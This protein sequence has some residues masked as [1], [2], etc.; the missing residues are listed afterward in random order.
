MMRRT[1]FALGAL[2]LLALFLFPTSQ[3]F[4]ASSETHMPALN[5]SGSCSNIH[6]T[7]SGVLNANCRMNNGTLHA[8]ALDLNPDVGNMNG[9]LVING[10]NFVASCSG[11][12]GGTILTASCRMAN[13]TPHSTS[14]NLNDAID[15]NNGTLVWDD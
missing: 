6:I 3:A 12:G 2:L 11:I 10:S 8:T 1:L 14:L 5:F 9:T 13:G 7:S 4:A 15:N